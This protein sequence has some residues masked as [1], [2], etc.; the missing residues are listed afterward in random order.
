MI[1]SHICSVLLFF[2]VP[3][4]WKELLLNELLSDSS[5]YAKPFAK[6]SGTAV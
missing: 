6:G 2:D 3:N 4:K 5:T 1:I